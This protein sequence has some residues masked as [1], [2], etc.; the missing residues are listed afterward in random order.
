MNNRPTESYWIA[1]DRTTRMFF[2][3]EC[4]FPDGIYYVLGGITFPMLVGSEIVGTAVVIGQYVDT[5]DIYVL[6]DQRFITVDPVVG[7][8]GMVQ[9]KGLSAWLNRVM[10]DYYLQQMFFRQDYESSRRCMDKIRHSNMLKT[11][12]RF[13][14]V[15]W[16]QEENF[17][18][19]IPVHEA[20][21]L[22]KLK[23]LSDSEIKKEMQQYNAENDAIYPAL[24]A[25]NCA[26][27]GLEK[28]PY[29]KKGIDI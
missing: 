9:Y 1:A 8:G 12:P 17:K 27:H 18:Q 10:S 29:R 14:N 22:Q 11:A 4:K 15:D 5:G 28:R 25:L 16:M 3:E 7:A 23:Y 21:A 20:D 24:H 19:M 2:A 6:N 26:L 13:I